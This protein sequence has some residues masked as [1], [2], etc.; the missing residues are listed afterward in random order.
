MYR[1][2]SN[3][4]SNVTVNATLGMDHTQNR[5]KFKR[6]HYLHKSWTGLNS[7]VRTLARRNIP[8]FQDDRFDDGFE[9]DVPRERLLDDAILRLVTRRF[10]GDFKT[11]FSVK[12]VLLSEYL[13]KKD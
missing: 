5:Y 2:G 13:L 12:K 8:F 7:A 4:Q 11:A 3:K 6:R 9:P 10:S 1:N